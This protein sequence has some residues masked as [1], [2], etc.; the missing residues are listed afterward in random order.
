M[1][2]HQCDDST[3]PCNICLH[4]LLIIRFSFFYFYKQNAGKYNQLLL[5]LLLLLFILAICFKQSK[6]TH[7][8]EIN[9]GIM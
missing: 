4:V 2:F 5:L 7:K 3:S 9:N 6:Y 1:R 8:L